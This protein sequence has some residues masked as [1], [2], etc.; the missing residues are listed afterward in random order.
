MPDHVLAYKNRDEFSPVM[1]SY[2]Q[3][4]HLWSDGG[5]PRP[6]LDHLSFLTL[7]SQRCD[8]FHEFGIQIG[9]LL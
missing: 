3:A 8:L 1:D 9:S 6:S 2:C 4:Y 5:T 7:G